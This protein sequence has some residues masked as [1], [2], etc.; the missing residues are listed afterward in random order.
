MYA[1]KKPAILFLLVVM[2]AACSPLAPPD[3]PAP[4]LAPALVVEPTLVPPSAT[5]LPTRTLVPT[6]TATPTATPTPT[7][8]AVPLT[9]T[10][11]LVPLADTERERIFDQVWELVRDRYLY[12]DYRG[13]DWQAARET[14]RPRALAAESPEQFYQ[15]MGELIRLLGDDH[16]RFESPRAVAEEELRKSGELSYAGI[17]VIVRDDPAGGLITRLARGGPAEQAGLRSHDLILA[18]GSTLFTDTAAFGP[19]GP[20]SVI[21]GAPG[22]TVQLTVRSPGAAPRVVLIARQMIPS[23]A[24]PPVVAQRL[25]GSQTGLLVIDT[26]SREGLEQLA[27]EQLEL[28]LN[29]RPLDGLIIDLRNNQ[30]GFVSTM[31]GTLGLFV[32][33]GSIGT[34]RGRDTRQ[35][36]EIPKGQIMPALDGVPIVVLVGDQTVSAAEMFAAGMRVRERARIVGVPS[37]GNTEN[38]LAHN[39]PDGSRL[40]LAQYAYY[41]PDGS[42]LEGQGVLP[43][44]TV[45]VEWWRFDPADD[46]QVQ[47]ALAELRMAN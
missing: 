36:Q 22:S 14:Y 15:A 40:W 33:G 42:L 44:R 20:N 41:L 29:D 34:T 6:P 9:P 38:L 43:D 31:L 26:F 12:A 35:K 37:A 4:T 30:G 18:V 27:R 21:R 32:D 8:T 10:A 47:A 25:P 7:A 13:V 5:P 24:F 16:S 39:L 19:G 17:G 46:P 3:V 1:M 45:D 2:L 23:D 11:T 28:L